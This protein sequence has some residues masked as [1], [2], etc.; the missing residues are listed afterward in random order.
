MQA[1]SS[2][3]PRAHGPRELSPP[4]CHIRP[5]RHQTDRRDRERSPLP[6]DAT[7]V[8]S[9][10]PYVT[11]DQEGEAGAC[12]GATVTRNA[13]DHSPVEVDLDPCAAAEAP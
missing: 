6:P 8:S 12:P 11:V 2:A 3:G 4:R 1:L 7:P 9:D 10:D 13:Y 5:G